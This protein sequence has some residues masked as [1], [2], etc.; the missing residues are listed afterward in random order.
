MSCSDGAP[1]TA[2]AKINMAAPSTSVR[3]PA[4][5]NRPM[6]PARRAR[7]ATDRHLPKLRP[8]DLIVEP[9]LRPIFAAEIS[10]SALSGSAFTPIGGTSTPV[11][12]IAKPS[13]AALS[14]T[15]D[16][17]YISTGPETRDYPP[18]MSRPESGVVVTFTGAAAALL[19]LAWDV[20]VH[21]ANPAGAAHESP[22]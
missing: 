21:T 17:R 1:A 5:R 6:R 16:A 18:D 13:R 9:P 3:H 4:A 19:G 22:V 10:T 12:P 20:S 11:Q 2:P 7:S 14:A 15:I 8:F